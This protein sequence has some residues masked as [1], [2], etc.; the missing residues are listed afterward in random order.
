MFGGAG[1][2]LRGNRLNR[3]SLRRPVDD[4]WLA[5]ASALDVPKREREMYTRLLEILL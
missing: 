1:V 5:C 4:M 2:R 3:Y